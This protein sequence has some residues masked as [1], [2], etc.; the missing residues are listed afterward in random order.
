MA[1]HLRYQHHWIFSVVA[2]AVW[3]ALGWPFL[4]SLATGTAPGG[5]AVPALWLAPFALFGAAVL[6]AIVLKLRPSLRWPLP[7]VQL[8]AVLAMAIIHPS[9][10][11]SVF[12][13]IIAWQV[14]MATAPVKALGWVAFQTLAVIGTLSLA[15][16]PDLSYVVALSFVLQLC[17][18]FTA[19]AL[20]REAEGARALAQ[21]NGELRSAQAILANNV[22]AAE[23][24]RISR[25]LHDAWGHELTA[26]GLQ[27]EI[28]SNVSEP[29]RANEHAMQAKGLARALL[30]K[31]RDAVATLRDTERRHWKDAL[32]GLHPLSSGDVS[33]KPDSHSGSALLMAGQGNRRCWFFFAAALAVCLTLGWPVV[34]QLTAGAEIRGSLV[35]ALWLVPFAMFAAAAFGAM[36]PTLPKGLLWTLLCVQVA[37]VLAMAIIVQWAMMS[38]FL[39]ITAWQVALATTPGKTLG[40][41]AVQT[42]AV[43]IA[44]VLI[45]NPDLC[46]VIGKSF[47]LQLFFVFTAQALRMEAE[48]ARALAQTNREL[49]SAQAIIAHTVR[50]A[51]R[52]RISRELHDAWG[53][54]LTAL[55]LQLEIASHVT[56]PARAHDHVM[57]AKGLARGLLA[58]VRDVVATLREAERRDL[59]DALEALAH[60]VPRPAIHVDISP[61]VRVS[62]DQTHAL[63]RCAQE[64]VTNA[65]KHAEASNLWLQVTS[66]GEGVRLIARNDGNARP[67][68]SSPGSGL[69]GM[70]ERV[71][72][73]GG[74]LAVQ[75]GAG[76]GFTVDAWL[77]SS[78]PQAA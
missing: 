32:Q 9:D 35:S 25:E 68:A 61:G 77:P 38:A 33:A 41:V 45:P 21:T 6:G 36:V 47:A 13:I 72:S 39:V 44:L 29:G 73:L 20:R 22:R 37:A 70:R 58:N 5:S 8:A 40:W 16:N 12:L 59:K 30:V 49:R 63:M 50:D 67:I 71:E 66:D 55:G 10:V 51:E 3:L 69:L 31:V 24:L 4:Q 48:T 18:V 27:L 78:A 17:F 1:G 19:H 54:E 34:Q 26:L 76:L 14:A 42:L 7:C 62:P 64:A 56:E 28:A 43:I 52:L 65:V 74:K 57:Q 53:H 60:S 75:A 15:P 11:M 46:W 23:R 2:L